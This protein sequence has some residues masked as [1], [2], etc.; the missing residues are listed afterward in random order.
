M[1][2]NADLFKE[3]LKQGYIEQSN[4]PEFQEDIVI[5]D[6]VIGDGIFDEDEEEIL[7]SKNNK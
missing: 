7:S 3:E 4:D 2:N 1:I 6:V 5:W